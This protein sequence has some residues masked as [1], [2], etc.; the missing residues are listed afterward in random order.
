[1]VDGQLL[2]AYVAELE[3]LRTHGRDFAQTFPDIAA[4]LDIGP[5]RSTDPQV[6]RLVESAAFLAARMRMMIESRATELP[7]SLLSILAP[8]LLEPVPSMALAELRAG[9]EPQVVPRGTRFDYHFSGQALVCFSTTMEVT[10]A[11]LSFRLRR[12]KPSSNYP[13]GIALQLVGTPPERLLLCLGNDE[14]SAAVLLDALSDDLAAIEVAQPG[15]AES[16]I[17]SPKRLQFHGF[18]AGD[19]ALPIRPASHQAHRIVTEFMAFPEKFRFVS[20]SGLPFAN[21]TEVRFLFSRPL[22]LAPALPRDLITVNRVPVVNLWP[23]AAT[24][25]DIVGNQLEYTVRV[26]AQRYRI[27]ECHS[28]EDVD[29]YGPEGNEPIRLDPTMGLGDI[30]NTTIRWGTR[31]TVSRAGGEVM[32]YF[33]GLDY[34]TLGRQRFLAAPHVLAS[35][36]DLPQRVRTGSR[37]DPVESLG[38]WRG[39]LATVP[40]VY[41]P[42][43]IESRAM[44]LLTGYLRSSVNGMTLGHRQGSLGDYLR[45]FPG[46]GDATWIDSIGRVAYRPVAAMRGGYPQAGLAIYVAFDSL[47]SRTTSRSMVK[48]VLAE[49]FESQR[50]LNRVEEVVVVSN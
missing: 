18:T 33:Q 47:R 8:T 30:R 27:L 20:L 25:F 19:A 48:R 41:R 1:M 38:G 43:L 44:R 15:S 46:G 40:R 13:D 29:M 11:P 12:Y 37:L 42:A 32:L 45:H 7:M 50:G 35:N 16:L 17:V 24:P 36:R 28:V 14:L 3:A 4:R 22:A 31:R 5:R 21:G 2:N 10:A 9:A 23:T 6:E 49:L 34:A 39:V 26:D